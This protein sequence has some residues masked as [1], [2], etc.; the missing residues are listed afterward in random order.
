MFSG[1]L[2][3]AAG[4]PAGHVRH[5]AQGPSM[6]NQ[7]YR[8]SETCYRRVCFEQSHLKQLNQ[9]SGA[10]ALYMQVWQLWRLHLVG[11]SCTARHTGSF[12]TS[13]NHAR[14]MLFAAS[15]QQNTKRGYG[16]SHT[17]RTYRVMTTAGQ[18]PEQG[19]THAEASV[20]ISVHTEVQLT[21]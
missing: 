12:R 17:N 3:V 5:T 16:S 21:R 20:Q 13:A 2:G 6:C 18:S 7:H 11:S 9:P 1:P 10:Y 8:Q 19:S 14:I 15:S 4:V